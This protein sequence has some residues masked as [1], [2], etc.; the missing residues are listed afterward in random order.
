MRI[1]P[2]IDIIDGKCVRLSKGD[3]DTKKIYNEDPLEV[4]KA[5]EDHGIRNLHLVD[6]DGAKSKQ[7]V[8]YRILETIASK[9]SLQIDFGGGI[10]SDEDLHMIFES[11]A[12]QATGGSIAV[13]SRET[14]LKWLEYYGPDR[15]ILGAD[16]RDGH[17]S[18]FGWQED[19]TEEVV[20]FI[21]SYQKKGIQYVICTEISKD[22]MLAGPAFDLYR[23]IL[24]K[25]AKVET[26]VG[27]SGVEDR[28]VPGIKLIASGGISGMEELPKL[29]Q[30]GCEGVIIG[31]AIYENR[32]TLKELEGYILM[33]S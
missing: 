27:P 2:A 18:V 14:F 21:K 12:R 31:K 20:P 13:K 8:N 16:C 4:A 19:S 9:T 15:I 22:G 25:T 7:V 1:I 23:E 6:L 3:Y 29:A 11:G 32:I 5:Y 26:S 10:K 30:I 28:E 33:Q 17:I 24:K